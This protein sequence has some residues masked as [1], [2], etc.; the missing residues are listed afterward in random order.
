MTYRRAGR[1][2]ARRR[3]ASVP[4]VLGQHDGL[5][6][7]IVRC[8]DLI[9]ATR[10]VIAD[11]DAG[12]LSRLARVKIEDRDPVAGVRVAARRPDCVLNRIRSLTHERARRRAGYRPI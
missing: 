1:F 5:E 4:T 2:G 12:L 8:R 11:S 6:Q 7:L 3:E 10:V 9:G